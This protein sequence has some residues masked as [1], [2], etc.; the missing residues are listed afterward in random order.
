VLDQSVRRHGTGGEAVQVEM[1]D[2]GFE[3]TAL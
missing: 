1:R 2:P 3:A